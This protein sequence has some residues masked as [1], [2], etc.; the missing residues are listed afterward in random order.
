MLSFVGQ[1]LAAMVIIVLTL[2]AAVFA[3]QKMS[4]L[5]PVH[6][7]LGGQASQTAIAARRHALGLDKPVVTQFGHYLTGLAHGDLGTSYRTR[8][9]VRT[10]LVAY[11]PA[12]LELAGT[13]LLIALALATVFAFAS[14]LKV[15]GSGA[16][17]LLLML[18][19]SV[20]TFLLGIFGILLF[21]Q[22]FG[23][24]PASGRTSIGDA[25]TGPTHLLTVDGLLHGRP[26]VTWDA[27]KHLVMPAT[28]I[29]L[30]PAVA[31]GRVLRSSLEG[32]LGG[33]YVRTARAKGRS[34]RQILFGHVLRNAIGAA[35]S[36]TG[37]QVGLM[38]AGVL[39]VE[40]VFGWPGLGLYI[41]ESIP[42]AD[43]PAIAGV[44]LLLGSAYVVI[45]A[46]VDLIQAAA[47]PRIRV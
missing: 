1:R 46:I 36:M 47:D 42:V 14:T 17:R 10:D 11:V 2:A 4:P 22:H 39:V 32:E 40:Q 15:P 19:A 18:G 28:A 44:T 8:R 13:G 37:L 3:L 25:P 30:G 12:T 35:V 7:Q 5:D 26:A 43:F 33:D 16:F 6:A 45:N 23:W 34:E 29:A 38:F 9:P 41:A 24:L 20:P 27:W 31:I 21:Y